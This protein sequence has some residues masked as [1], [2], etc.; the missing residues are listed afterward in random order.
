MFTLIFVLAMGN[1]GCAQYVGSPE[2]SL[3]VPSGA[4]THRVAPGETLWRIANEYRVEVSNLARVNRISDASRIQAG[5]LLVIPVAS[6]STEI[7]RPSQVE[8]GAREDLVW[9]VEGK[10]ISV[11][12]M[13]RAGTVNKGIDIQAP[14]GKEVVN[15]ALDW[16]SLGMSLLN[17]FKKAR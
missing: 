2:T 5:Q 11:F 14:K 3:S 16:L 7:S 1:G 13:R 8:N 4:L 10:V 15:T 17:K 6:G 12:G 9:P